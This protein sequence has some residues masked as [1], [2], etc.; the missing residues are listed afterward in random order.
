MRWV[1]VLAE[2]ENNYD[3]RV[4]GPCGNKTRHASTKVLCPQLLAGGRREKGSFVK[5]I[6]PQWIFIETLYQQIRLLEASWHFDVICNVDS[7]SMNA[8]LCVAEVFLAPASSGEREVDGSANKFG[9]HRVC[10]GGL[11]FGLPTI[12][13]KLVKRWR[14]RNIYVRRA[15]E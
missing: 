6:P 4:C 11:S 3:G 1:G 2:E 5:T 8:Q 7:M 15:T 14:R 9:K 12:L 13:R 10:Q